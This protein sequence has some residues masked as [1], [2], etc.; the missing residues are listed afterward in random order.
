M[1]SRDPRFAHVARINPR[2]LSWRWYRFKELHAAQ[3]YALLGLRLAVFSVE[4]Q[5]IY[6]DLDGLDDRAHHL[7][8]C[9]RL[10]RDKAPEAPRRRSDASL[11]LLAYARCLPPGLKGPQPSFGRVV[12]EPA[13]RGQGLGHE[14]VRRALLRCR[15]LYPGMDV[16]IS[17][18]AHLQRF[19][20]A[21]GFRSV[22]EDYLEDG[23][24][25]REMLC[26]LAPRRDSTR[27][28]G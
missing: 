20:A 21:H 14:V 16:R 11:A 1:F 19:Y 5:C 8:G 2:A 18:Q 26:S 13:L 3:L 28:Q 27:L 24:A 4:Q 12:V 7:L 15:R 17:A 25:H 9:G 23:I 22:G 10:A 6:Q